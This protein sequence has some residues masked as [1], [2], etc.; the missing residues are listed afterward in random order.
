[1]NLANTESARPAAAR[2]HTNEA[3]WNFVEWD[4]LLQSP[5]PYPATERELRYYL[6]LSAV[7]DCTRFGE[8][9]FQHRPG[10]WEAL[11][12]QRDYRQL[13]NWLDGAG[14]PTFTLPDCCDILGLEPTL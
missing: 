14:P 13:V 5:S 3:A 1:M 11:A 10:S 6:V 8:F 7:E 12:E 2:R 9:G 4:T